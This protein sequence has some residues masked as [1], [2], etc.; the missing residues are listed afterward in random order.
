MTTKEWLVDGV[1]FDVDDT[2]VDTRRAFAHALD[3]VRGRYLPATSAEHLDEMLHHWRSDPGGWYRRYTRG[4]TDHRTQRRHRATLLHETFG[5]EPVTEKLFDEWDELFWGTFEESWTPFADAA[6]ALAAARDAGL[7]LGVVTNASVELQERKLAAVGLS[8]LPV[9]VGVD[10]LGF[11]KPDPRVFTE[12]ARLLGTDPGRTAYVGD[13]PVVDAAAARDAGLLGVW[14]ARRGVRK[15]LGETE[16]HDAMRASG[17][18]VISG[19][20][21]LP[22]A[23]SGGRDHSPVTA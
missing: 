9:L 3:A 23:L 8:G 15:R 10:T 13:E 17:I 11:G 21:E 6:P 19:L 1:L 5:G 22:A 7:R 12:G 2:L 20:D 14:L 4:E 16:D 18:A